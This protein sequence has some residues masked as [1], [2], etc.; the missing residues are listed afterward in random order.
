[1]YRDVDPRLTSHNLFGGGAGLLYGVYKPGNDFEWIPTVKME[2]KLLVG[3]SCGSKFPSIYNHCGVMEAWS[4]K[5]L[6]KWQFFRFYRKMTHYRESFKIL[7]PKDSSPHRS[8]CCV[9]ISWNLADGKSVK[10]CVAYMTKNFA[11]LFSCRYCVDRAQNMP[12][13]APRMYL[14]CPRLHPN[15]FTFGGVISER[16]NTVKARSKVNLWF[17]WSP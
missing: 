11:W 2:T 4:R 5:T 7:F 13:P 16:V 10:S 1:M 6:K 3:R 15:R 12:G 9:Q 8:T 17:G 14:E